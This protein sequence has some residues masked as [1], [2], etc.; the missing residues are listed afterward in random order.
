V[1]DIP[2]YG[3]NHEEVLS[4]IKKGEWDMNSEEWDSITD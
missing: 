1:G 2:F 3:D 4:A